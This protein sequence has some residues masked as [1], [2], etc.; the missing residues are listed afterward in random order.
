[1]RGLL[2]LTL[3]EL[4]LFL[5]EPMAAFFTL[6][7]PLILLFVFGSIF[8]NDLDPE[9][10]GGTWGPVDVMVQGYIGLII[11]TIVFIGMP[12][13]ISNYR[14]FGILKRLRATPVTAASIVGAQV[15]VNL[16][17][18]VLGVVLLLVIG[19]IVYDLRM[20]ENMLGMWAASL[21]SFLSF[22]AV[23][24]VL[25]SL[26]PTSR[27]A[28]AV[29]SA[30]YF[31]QMFLSGAAFPREMFPEGMKRATEFLPMTQI[32]ILITEIWQKGTWNLTAVVVLVI[33]GV[34][35]GVAAVKL[36]RWE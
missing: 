28:Q 1:M 23:G 19:R 35:A 29:G 24:L 16:I 32:N 5:R 17:M 3:S 25:A 30:I 6:A 7:F 15:I 18:F 2:Q 26:F 13:T 12:V 10:Y 20:P 34:V 33:I 9:H 27:T 36:F 21:L 22:A 11:G 31:P 4:K 14:Q 8:G